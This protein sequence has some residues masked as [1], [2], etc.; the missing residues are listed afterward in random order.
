MS[1]RKVSCVIRERK[2]EPP[3]LEPLE[4]EHCE[5]LKAEVERLRRRIDN[6]KIRSYEL[7]QKELHNMALEALQEVGDER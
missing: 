3:S 5:A 1:D 2:L 7:G 6:I 4:C